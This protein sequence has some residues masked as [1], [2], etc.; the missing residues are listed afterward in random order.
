MSMRALERSVF[1]VV[2]GVVKWSEVKLG[3][4]NCVANHTHTS[5]IIR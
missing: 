5:I 2:L 4:C 3:Y 1:G